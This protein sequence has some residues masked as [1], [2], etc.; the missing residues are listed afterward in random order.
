MSTLFSETISNEDLNQLPAGSFGGKI[1]VV[2]TPEDAL[3]ACEYLSRQAVIGFDTETRPSFKKGV[4]NRVSLLQLSSEEESFLFRL[5]KI[6]LEKPIIKL[7][8]SNSVVKIGLAIRDDLRSMKAL[9]QFTPKQF[10]DL[11]SI[12]GEYGI[13]E[14]SLR[15]LAAI[16]LDIRISKAQRL[17]NWEASTLTPAQQ[18]YAATDA[19]VSREIYMQLMAVEPTPSPRARKNNQEK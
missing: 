18:L 19:W 6:P 14:L 8:E 4:T 11:Q 9:R 3:A 15:K 1:T 12:V 13:K 7:M 5:N 16:V 17:S 2:E 10:V